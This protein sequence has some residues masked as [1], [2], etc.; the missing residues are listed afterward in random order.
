MKSS[1]LNIVRRSADGNFTTVANAALRD[2]RISYRAKGILAAC[3]S[4]SDGFTLSRAWIDSH[5]TEGREAIT[6]AIRELRTFG[7]VMDE[8]HQDQPGG[9]IT[10]K[11]VW[12][13]MA[14]VPHQDTDSPCDRKPVGRDP[15]RTETPSH[16][17]KTNFQEEQLKENQE[18]KTPFIPLSEAEPTDPATPAPK[19]RRR[20]PKEDFFPVV[21][22]I[23]ATLLP[24]A[25]DLLAFWEAKEGART[26]QAWRLLLTELGKIQNDVAGGTSEVRGQLQ[27]GVQVGKW[28]CITHRNWRR[29]G[30]Q[31]Q[32][33]LGLPNGSSR[34]TQP[35][36]VQAQEDYVAGIHAAEAAGLFRT[37][38]TTP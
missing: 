19:R 3:L 29:Y 12:T 36:R 1:A 32:T 2:P 35:S 26:Q 24:V 20:A 23:P 8:Y 13:D 7:Y 6:S 10:R 37:P 21:D 17:K 11:L 28:K 30:L 15:G 9:Q 14:Q 4:H 27:Q 5:G 33:A 16:I 38:R 34:R 25:H 31:G 22:D 18:D